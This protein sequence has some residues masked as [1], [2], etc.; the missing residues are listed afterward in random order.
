MAT[1]Y[2]V[3][4]SGTWDGSST[5]NWSLTSGGAGGAGVPNSATDDV[6]FNT[7]SSAASY[8][9]TVGYFPSC[10]GITT[11]APAAGTLTFQSTPG[12]SGSGGI[13][14]NQG[15][16]FA[17]SDAAT[18]NI[19]AACLFNNPDSASSCVLIL[20]SAGNA[21]PATQTVTF[22]AGA[23]AAKVYY[24]YTGNFNTA[25]SLNFC[26]SQ[27]ITFA[28]V[29]I[30]AYSN[31]VTCTGSNIT[32]A[33]SLAD[34]FYINGANNLT[35]TTTTVNM[36]SAT[37]VANINAYISFNGTG[38][39]AVSS[40]NINCVR[41][42]DTITINGSGTSIT[43]MTLRGKTSSST[44]NVYNVSGQSGTTTFV[45]IL[46]NYG[47]GSN[48]TTAFTGAVT[49]NSATLTLF[50][51]V[52]TFT[53]GS[54]LTLNSLGTTGG[55]SY[56]QQDTSS[57]YATSIVFTG[58]V[59]LA[60]TTANAEIALYTNY[61][62]SY[63]TPAITFSSTLTVNMSA[64][65]IGYISTSLEYFS[66]S[67]IIT[68]AGATS[69]TNAYITGY[70][71]WVQSGTTTF[72]S[73]ANP[74]AAS[75]YIQLGSLS[76]GTG[77]VSLTSTDTRFEYY[78][79]VTNKSLSSSGPVTVNN[80]S[81]TNGGTF[82]FG[83]WQASF[84]A[85]TVV[86]W[87][88]TDIQGNA[89]FTVT[90]A[91]G[92]TST[93]TF[94]KTY[95]GFAI[96]GNGSLSVTGPLTVTNAPTGLISATLTVGGNFSLTYSAAIGYVSN[97]YLNLSGLATISGTC[98][99]SAPA[100][101]S[102]Y[103][104]FSS[105]LQ[106]TS[107]AASFT[108][109]QVLQISGT[110]ATGGRSFYSTGTFTLNCSTIGTPT[111]GAPSFL[112][113]KTIA[114]SAFSIN[115]VT[116]TIGTNYGALQASSSTSYTAG[117]YGSS[118]WIYSD[119]SNPSSLGAVTTN[120]GTFRLDSPYTETATATTISTT[121]TTLDWADF[122]V[123][124][125]GAVSVTGDVA[126]TNSANILSLIGASSVSFTNIFSIIIPGASAVGTHTLKGTTLTVNNSALTNP[127]TTGSGLTVGSN[128]YG[129][130][131]TFTGLATFNN[132]NV[133]FGNFA[134]APNV[135]CVGLTLTKGTYN[136]TGVTFGPN[137][138]HSIGAL[139]ATTGGSFAVSS[140]T[141]SSGAISAT[142]VPFSCSSVGWTAAG[143]VAIA[144]SPTSNSLTHAFGYLINGAFSTTFTSCNISFNSASP[145]GA[146]SGTS[147][148]SAGDLVFNDTGLASA[149]TLT[150][151][152]PI[153]FV[154]GATA[155]S[156]TKK[157]ISSN[158]L[159]VTGAGGLTLTSPLISD[160][161]SI[162]NYINTV[163]ITGPLTLTSQISPYFGTA[164]TSG[165]LV[166]TGASG[167]TVNFFSTL[168]TGAVT[169]GGGTVLTVFGNVVMGAFNATSVAGTTVNF[170]G[171]TVSS[172]T[173]TA[174][175]TTFNCAGVGWTAAGAASFSA[176]P[177][178]ASYSAN[179]GYFINGA[180]TTTFTSYDVSFASTSPSGP[181]A[182]AGF[183]STGN[184]IVD[185]SGRASAGTF[186]A[187]SGG[188]VVFVTGASVTTWSKVIVDVGGLTATGA[189]GLLL[190]N[191]ATSDQGGFNSSG[192]VSITGPLT[193]TNLKISGGNDAFVCVALS[194]GGAFTAN[195]SFSAGATTWVR[196]TS[197]AITGATT[198]TKVGLF[199]SGNYA[200]TGTASFTGE[201]SANSNVDNT[202][203]VGGTLSTLTG[204]SNLTIANYYSVSLG[205]VAAGA[206]LSLTH[207]SQVVY[208]TC[209]GNISQSAVGLTTTMTRV[210]L[211]GA[212]TSTF[213]SYGALTMTAGA[214]LY[215]FLS[216]DLAAV[217]SNAGS[218]S[219]ACLSA[220]AMT[221]SG[222]VSLTNT[223]VWVNDRA[224][225]AI[226]VTGGAS[227]PF[228]FTIDAT[229]IPCDRYDMSRTLSANYP[230]MAFSSFTLTNSGS[231]FSITSATVYKRP[232]V[233]FAQSSSSSAVISIPSGVTPTL[234]NVDFWRI[235]PG[236]TSTKPWTGTSLG[237][238]GATSIAD[239]TTTAPKSV[240]YVGGAGSWE[241]AKWAT[242]SGGTGATANYPLPQD[243][244]NF[245]ANSGGG[246]VTAPA[247]IQIGSLFLAGTSPGLTTIST[248]V[249]TPSVF[250]QIWVSRGI[251]GPSSDPGVGNVFS[252]GNTS[253]IAVIFVDGGPLDTVTVTNSENMAIGSG[254]YIYYMNA[255]TLNLPQVAYTGVS[256][257]IG[258]QPYTYQ[259]QPT[260][261]SIDAST[262]VINITSNAFTTNQNFYI[263]S[264]TFNLGSCVITTS[265]YRVYSGTV[266]IPS[267]PY[268]CVV[269][270]SYTLN[271]TVKESIG[272]AN[273]AHLGN[274]TYQV[275]VTSPAFSSSVD[276]P[277]FLRVQ[278]SDSTAST[279]T[280][281][282]TSLGTT[283]RLY[284]LSTFTVT[285]NSGGTF[286]FR[287]T[288]GGAITLTGV[289][290]ARNQWTNIAIG[291]ASSTQ[292]V[293]VLPATPAT[294][295]Y[296][297]GSLASG[298]TGWNAGIAPATNTGFFFF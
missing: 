37:P 211:S 181:S 153:T 205:T 30:N 148:Y 120:G 98:T 151:T 22:N 259:S 236:G 133:F 254:S 143:T 242:S 230:G 289:A 96:G 238:V 206:A 224:S 23:G 8:V 191:L 196:L 214:S 296:S 142:N 284:T 149:G 139:T 189:G 94:T 116:T 163:N 91:G 215:D 197:A 222:A 203:N 247:N 66:N 55:G 92:L 165:S 128:G 192:N 263:S 183:Y 271:A 138:A 297:G 87:T 177:T 41:T 16:L 99:V 103:V 83:Q 298:Q 9:V 123:T 119:G 288:T 295:Y 154:S 217:T 117:T 137:G 25:V 162:S 102:F 44:A 262:R 252:L 283:R 112:V 53:F 73:T 164:V 277:T 257:P 249:T 29:E 21:P 72:T 227:K 264:G 187:L 109:I 110:G 250:T 182:G 49:L 35:L 186:Y 113:E 193:L 237:L 278:I 234:T 62:G 32:I 67:Q 126:G 198:F 34:Y 184:L 52:G 152:N 190:T 69:L 40:F 253:N 124:A 80:G 232:L 270:S 57:Y 287:N 108:N 226:V 172:T 147:F 10:K 105:G 171:S 4:G 285:N 42:Y 121:N 276:D 15:P 26:L 85:A 75:T 240:Y 204:A 127:N 174:S 84:V 78:S 2:W 36:G 33:N 70:G 59:S 273:A 68:C 144:S 13:P 188:T 11:A 169:L 260:F 7:A 286:N 220:G 266:A 60:G 166:T 195:N 81:R 256:L 155:T 170:S 14:A 131:I 261:V 95:G 267:T 291:V 223:D 61:Y 294:W 168:N 175:N 275:N 179:F 239:L 210:R 200:S 3:G 111:Y 50:N 56:L 194:V 255:G 176:S 5:T 199:C 244:I 161:A 140:G 173:I 157:S 38:T 1:F 6:V 115:N 104:T 135:T 24:A 129:L 290:G 281:F 274:L 228:S 47:Q 241:D 107:G 229:A 79:P 46:V 89:A 141:M 225:G 74:T 158:G 39:I 65:Y 71:H 17:V 208:A 207:A 64:G 132:V 100:S 63:S 136:D 248:S 93:N 31:N 233:S 180:F 235:A 18:I 12:A 77:A 265:T 97:A 114:C 45:D 118:F 101:G 145:S 88:D 178:S 125:S 185:L 293:N 258:F 159:T 202:F 58:A 19:H 212:T 221:F 268:T 43:N 82:N 243:N 48:Y 27:T 130:P 218:A 134:S 245:D 150:A 209:S 282:V 216:F 106:M 167:Q 76:M 122:V 213:T 54:T 246:T 231:T 156:W 51:I 201:G 219:Y 279:V 20:H 280:F 28:G 251:T 272:G 160:G 146:S 86:T 90:G 269:S 292:Y